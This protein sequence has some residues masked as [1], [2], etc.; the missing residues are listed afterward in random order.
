MVFNTALLTSAI[1]STSPIYKP[2]FCSK[3]NLFSLLLRNIENEYESNQI[4]ILEIIKTLIKQT[5]DYDKPLFYMVK[6]ETKKD[7]AEEIKDKNELRNIITLPI[8]ETIFE[9]D[10]DLL[11]ILLKILE[12]NDKSF[13]DRCNLEYLPSLMKSS[14]K[15]D[16]LIKFIELCMN[17]I[18]IKDDLCLE[19]MKQIL[20]LPVLIVKPKIFSANTDDKIDQQKWPLFGAQLILNNNNDLNTEIYKYTCFYRKQ[21]FCILSYL[22]PCRS[23]IETDIKKN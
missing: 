19:R 6:S 12:Y 1:C 17:I 5:K 13:T 15:K 8:I 4:V 20:G 3:K 11:L 9:K 10:N 2:S 16:K 7:N 23:E 21:K 22:L 14:K 18:D